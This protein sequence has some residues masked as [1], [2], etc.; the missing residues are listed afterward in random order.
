MVFAPTG[1]ILELGA[2]GLHR[3]EVRFLI[4]DQVTAAR[5]TPAGSAY[6]NR[7]VLAGRHRV[8]VQWRGPATRPTRCVARFHFLTRT[9]ADIERDAPDVAQ[10]M[11]KNNPADFV[12]CDVLIVSQRPGAPYQVFGI[13]TVD[14]DALASGNPRAPVLK[15]DFLVHDRTARPPEIT[16]YTGVPR[17][18]PT[19]SHRGVLRACRRAPVRVRARRRSV[20]LQGSSLHAGRDRGDA[21]RAS[22]S[23][24]DRSCGRTGA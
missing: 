13:F 1:G 24:R 4:D 20:A 15:Q 8:G 5:E 11:K 23:R 6:T 18:W 10:V 3:Y 9:L 12:L 19:P 22:V 2:E 16:Y 17:A 21:S 7:P 14:K